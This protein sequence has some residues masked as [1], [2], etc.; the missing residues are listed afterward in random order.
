MFEFVLHQCAVCSVL[1][2]SEGDDLWWQSDWAQTSELHQYIILIENTNTEHRAAKLMCY[3]HTHP[4]RKKEWE[5]REVGGGASG[6]CV[7]VCWGGVGWGGFVSAAA[8]FLEI[9]HMNIGSSCAAEDKRKWTMRAGAKDN[10][11]CEKVLLQLLLT[12]QWE[13][14]S[15]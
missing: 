7:S 3:M 13:A 1:C 11:Q 2:G 9:F 15:I 5:R 6:V 12:A 14:I 8:H 4:C 10:I